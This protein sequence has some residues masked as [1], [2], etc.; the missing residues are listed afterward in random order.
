MGCNESKKSTQSLISFTEDMCRELQDLQKDVAN[1]ARVQACWS[2]NG[3]VIAKDLRGKIKSVRY[4]S[5]W[6]SVPNACPL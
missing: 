3:K 5:N 1:H 4:G 2:W 6:Q